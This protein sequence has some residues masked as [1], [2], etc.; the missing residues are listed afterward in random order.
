MLLARVEKAI[1]GAKI[2]LVA[3]RS[4]RMKRLCNGIMI[5]ETVI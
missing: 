2:E 5:Y 3:D 1:H 4:R